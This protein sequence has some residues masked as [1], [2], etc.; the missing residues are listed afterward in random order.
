VPVPALASSEVVREALGD[1]L[2]RLSDPR[3]GR[4]HH[5]RRRVADL[6]QATVYYGTPVVTSPRARELEAA[7]KPHRAD[8]AVRYAWDLPALHIREHQA[9]GQSR[10]RDLR[11]LQRQKRR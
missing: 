5:R 10:S 1:E 2:Q 8:R 11:D 4:H 9:I 7:V 6:R 3:L